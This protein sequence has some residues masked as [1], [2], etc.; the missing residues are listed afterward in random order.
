MSA[1]A[2]NRKSAVKALQNEF[3]ELMEAPVEGFK[4][5][6]ADESNLFAWDVAI[7]GPPQTLYEGGYFKVIFFFT[8]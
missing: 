1:L 4:V 3:K 7:F 8:V 5:T 6:L 2:N